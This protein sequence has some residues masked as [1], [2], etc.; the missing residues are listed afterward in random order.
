MK[1]EDLAALSDEELE[2]RYEYYGKRVKFWGWMI[3]VCLL[4]LGFELGLALGK[5]V[6]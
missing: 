2:Q 1:Y 5:Y 4:L 6:F 3:T